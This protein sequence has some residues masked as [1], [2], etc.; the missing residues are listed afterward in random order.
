MDRAGCDREGQG[1]TSLVG[2]EWTLQSL[3]SSRRQQSWVERAAVE[4]GRKEAGEASM[5]GVGATAEGL[6]HTA[7]CKVT[8]QFSGY[9]CLT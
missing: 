4:P 1:R 6:C 8:K 2:Q 5:P 7:H 9:H 3:Q